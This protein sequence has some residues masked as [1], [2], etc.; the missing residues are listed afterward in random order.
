MDEISE[1]EYQKYVTDFLIEFK[2]LI[3]ENRLYI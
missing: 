2:A 3:H 1:K